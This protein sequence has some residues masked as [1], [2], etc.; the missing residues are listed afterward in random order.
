MTKTQV[1]H[2]GSSSWPLPRQY[3]LSVAILAAGVIARMARRLHDSARRGHAQ[4]EAQREALR[5]T[6][7]SIGDAVITTDLHGRIMFLNHVA[8][9]LTGWPCDLAVGRPLPQVFRVLREE[10][11]MPMHNPVEQVL[12]LGRV[13]DLAR[14][15]LL[16]R[17]DGSERPIDDSAAPLRDG[18]GGI[19]GVV[20]VFRDVTARRAAE[21]ALRESEQCFRAMADTARVLIWITDTA[22]MGTWFNHAWLQF[23]GRSLEQERGRGWLENV[24][25]NDREHCARTFDAALSQRCLYALD[26]R[27][28]RFDGE[29]RWLVDN[30]AP[31]FGPDGN[32]A[33]Y[34][35][36]CIDITDRKE[37]EHALAQLVAQL[38]DADRRKDEFLATLAHELR[39]PLAPMMHGVDIMKRDD[40]QPRQVDVARDI[41]GRQVRHLVRLIDD[42]MDVSR[43][44]RDKLE[45][46]RTQ[47]DLREVLDQAV[48][49]CRPALL[50]S[51]QQ[52]ASDMPAEPVVMLADPARLIQ[53]FSN[54]LANAHHYSEPGGL[55][56]LS[57]Q[58]QGEQVLVSVKDTGVG[59]AQDMLPRIFDLFAQGTQTPTRSVR[60]LGIG[61]TLAKR[62]VEMH[63]GEV[64]ALSE[65][66]GRGSEF[67]VRLPIA[68]AQALP[69]EPEP[70]APASTYRILVVDDN[71]DAATTL[72]MLLDLAGHSIRTAHDGVA[73][74]EAAADYRPDVVLLDIGLPKLNGLEVA[75][76]L[77]LEPWGKSLVLVAITGWGQETDRLASHESG[78][79]AH[80]VKPVDHATLMSVL[81]G[82]M[83]GDRD[84]SRTGTAG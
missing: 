38:R 30:G 58:W 45:L 21:Q 73:A 42:L 34:I 10:T 56:S 28:R 54:L 8:E 68:A 71:L 27:L 57:V 29:Y 14:P 17:R 70:A 82:L 2:P 7:A 25:P 52:L 41:I 26:Y 12:K 48:E 20:L 9:E 80:L 51:R 61:L 49:I 23:T 16:V 69:A 55:V 13:V 11:R 63:G 53:V 46:H 19:T 60:G 32:F 64:Q 6:L 84:E 76:R 1:V 37:A 39:N 77:R 3:L 78:F 83:D 72:A 67:I 33:G 35:G 31:R 40:A 24:H 15:S 81:A 43:I 47:V 75:R 18:A 44:T 65:G 36:S 4:A 50:A 22:L 66:P 62:L 59:I 5:V 74:L 79:D